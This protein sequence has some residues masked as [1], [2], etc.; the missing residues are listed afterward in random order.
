MCSHFPKP[1]DRHRQAGLRIPRASGHI[2]KDRTVAHPVNNCVVLGHRQRSH[3]GQ[4]QVCVPSI[5]VCARARSARP[6]VPML[7]AAQG[8]SHCAV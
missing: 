3:L 2:L 6:G 7:P 4:G 5:Q 8:A 1:T